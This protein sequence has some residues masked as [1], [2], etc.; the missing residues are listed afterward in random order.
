MSAAGGIHH[1]D[2]GQRQRSGRRRVGGV[3]QAAAQ[4]GQGHRPS[5]RSPGMEAVSEKARLDPQHELVL[6]CAR[7][8]NPASPLNNDV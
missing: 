1:A 6:Q 2:I 8:G 7:R 3:A 5:R 4:P